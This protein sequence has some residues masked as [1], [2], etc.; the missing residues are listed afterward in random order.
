MK[1]SLTL[2]VVLISSIILAACGNKNSNVATNHSSSSSKMEKATSKNTDP[3]KRKWTY[4]NNI[5]DAGIETYKFTKT[6]IRD[7]ATVG[8]KCWS[9]IAI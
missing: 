2:G 6:E 7:S 4:K 1:K 5:F 8:K 3:S 9:C